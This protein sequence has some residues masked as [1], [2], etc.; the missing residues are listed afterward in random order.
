M[1]PLW[2]L[3]R[4]RALRELSVIPKLSYR[5]PRRFHWTISEPIPNRPVNSI[6]TASG[7]ASSF[8]PIHPSFNLGLGRTFSKNQLNSRAK[9]VK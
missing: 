9:F 4:I 2:N 3:P 7:T 8:S 1:H 6:T 5:E